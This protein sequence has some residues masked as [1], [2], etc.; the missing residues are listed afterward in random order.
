MAINHS[1][2]CNNGFPR[3]TLGETL[4]KL[5]K[6]RGMGQKDLA[7]V[8]G[9]SM[10]AIGMWESNSREPS[11]AIREKICDLFNVDYNYLYGLTPVRDSISDNGNV[12]LIPLFKK[13]F[14]SNEPLD[15]Q[16]ADCMIVLPG[17]FLANG[18][19]YF[20]VPTMDDS[21]STIG[22]SRG[23]ILIFEPADSVQ[24]YRVGCYAA[25]REFVCEV[26]DNSAKQAV[27]AMVACCVRR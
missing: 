26:S 4:R 24:Q 5:R 6:E 2:H 11:P 19:D 3:R 22:Y 8:L 9:C 12:L 21:L 10:S 17:T 15:I 16:G 20:A 27:G 25:G 13:P 7:D 23:S 14:S 18:K 1:S